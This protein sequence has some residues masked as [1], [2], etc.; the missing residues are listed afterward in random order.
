M[1]DESAGRRTPTSSLSALSDAALARELARLAGARLLELRRALAHLPPR[2]L[3]DRGDADAQSLLAS[4]LTAARP[5][6]AVL[7]EE[8]A[9][10]RL[11]LDADRVWIVDPLDGTREYSENRSD[12]AVHVALWQ[13]GDL[14][15]GAV[16][17]P[18]LDTV[19]TS[20]PA[21]AVPPRS[22][23]AP[24]RMAV[25]RS[26]PP[27]IA[28]GVAE[29]LGAELVEMGSAG[30]KVAAVVRGEADLYVHGGGQYEWDSAA[31]VAVARAAGLHASRLDGSPLRYN[32]PDPFLPDLVVCRPGVADEVLG[33]I[34]DLQ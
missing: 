19:L 33:V 4:G 25:S 5:D 34:S 30:F 7:S 14:V 13:R 8:A 10:D 28:T 24:L 22:A 17:L 3:K 29:A 9:D 16:A 27:A 15:T 2:E 1:L 23:S 6:D 26:R 12:W 32:Q 20:D 18:G 31:P 11:R 21:P